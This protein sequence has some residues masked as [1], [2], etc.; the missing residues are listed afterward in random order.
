MDKTSLFTNERMFATI[1]TNIRSFCF[2]GK[3]FGG[4]P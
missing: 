1:K 4:E 2:A 3:M